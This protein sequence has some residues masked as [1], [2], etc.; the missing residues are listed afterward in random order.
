MAHQFENISRVAK[1]SV[2]GFREEVHLFEE[3]NYEFGKRKDRE[4]IKKL[5]IGMKKWM[6][7]M[8]VI[9]PS[10]VVGLVRC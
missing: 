7:N 4:N 10:E 3:N 8:Y 9:K 5:K 6:I 2:H 1:H